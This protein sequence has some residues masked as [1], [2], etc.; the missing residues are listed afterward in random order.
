M[1]RVNARKPAYGFR[2][3]PEHGRGENP[4][5]GTFYARR[6]ESFPI[7]VQSR[8]LKLRGG[9]PD[10]PRTAMGYIVARY[11][12]LPAQAALDENNKSGNVVVIYEPTPR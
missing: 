8:M 1:R 9:I 4:Y 12:A 2:T 5:M 10:R 3:N 6:F 7:P 11:A